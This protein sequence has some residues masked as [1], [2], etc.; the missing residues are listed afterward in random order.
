[1]GLGWF[2]QHWLRGMTGQAIR[3][4]V[5]AAA[6]QQIAGARQSA[7]EA[8]QCPR[9]CDVGI[10]FALANESG[11]LEDLLEGL[12]TTRGDGFAIR[13]GQWRGRRVALAISGAGRQAAS[14][15]A[16][17]LILGHHPAHVISAGF[18]GGLS[19]EV[20]RHEIVVADS[21]TDAAGSLLELDPSRVDPALLVGPPKVHVGRLLTADQ[22]AR[23]A[24]EKRG[25]GEKYR[26]LAV[27]LESFAVAEVCR[28]E[29]LPLLVIR[30]VTD[31][32]DDELPREVERLIQQ[33]TRAARWGAAFA[34]ILGRPSVVKDLYQLREN[35]LV[36][37]DRLA[38]FL[39]RLIERLAPAGNWVNCA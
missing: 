5:T 2:L 21:L 35:A 34:A 10:V 11:G 15:A 9:A 26:A 24:A 36:A 23:G 29:G 28:R 22:I 8:A 33:K 27:D 17:A 1:M 14:R 30:V 39:T 19:P 3:D 25:R 4:T 32:V 6:H 18:C 31:A 13:Q 16:D 20:G 7:E 12:I 38:R 37:S